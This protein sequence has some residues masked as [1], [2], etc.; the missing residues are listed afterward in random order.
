MGRSF[1]RKF[2]AV[3]V[4]PSGLVLFPSEMQKI[5]KNNILSSGITEV[6]YVIF[7]RIFFLIQHILNIS[8]K[9]LE[10]IVSQKSKSNDII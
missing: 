7:G 10:I 4:S 9:Q 3:P 2:T 1:D 5:V 6:L 8:T